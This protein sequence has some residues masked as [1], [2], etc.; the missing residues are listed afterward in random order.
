MHRS[1]VES[2]SLSE[3][4]FPQD[5]IASGRQPFAHS[6]PS[7]TLLPVRKKKPPRFNSEAGIHN[8]NLVMIPIAIVVPTV[9][10][11]VPPSVIPGEASLALGIQVPPPLVRLPAAFAVPANRLIQF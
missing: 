11:A 5:D 4:F 10:A 7:F 2:L 6:K 9:V 8:R 1:F 3:G